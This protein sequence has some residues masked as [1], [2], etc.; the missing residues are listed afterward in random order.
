MLQAMLQAKGPAS[1]T[2]VPLLEVPAFCHIW[3]LLTHLGL[4]KRFVVVYLFLEQMATLTA[5]KWGLLL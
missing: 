2:C 5:I 1:L 3:Y 4:T